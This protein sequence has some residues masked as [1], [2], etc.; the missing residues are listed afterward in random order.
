MMNYVKWLIVISV[1]CQASEALA[2]RSAERLFARCARLMSGLD[3]PPPA[4]M[5]QVRAGDKSYVDACI[6][7]L[8]RGTLNSTTGELADNTGY[9]RNVLRHL[10]NLHFSWL[11]SK[12]IIAG[13]TSHFRFHRDLS[14][15]SGPALFF[16]RAL[17][18]DSIDARF[19]LNGQHQEAIR[20][21]M[22]PTAPMLITGQFSDPNP[23]IITNLT[24]ANRGALIGVRTNTT[25]TFNLTQVGPTSMNWFRTFGRGFIG[26]QTYIASVQAALPNADGG[27]RMPRL[28]GRNV[29]A[30]ALCMELPVVRPEDASGF[31]AP[32]SP[33][34]FRNELGCVGCHAS[35]DRTAAVI[36]NLKMQRLGNNQAPY[37][38]VT[39]VN[40]GP[41]DLAAES[42]WPRQPD[43]QYHR[44][45]TNGRL[46]F[47]NH[48]GALIDEPVSGISNLGAKIL[49]QDDFYICLAKRYYEYFTGVSANVRDLRGQT[50]LEPAASHRQ[51]VIDMGLRLKNHRDLK[52]TIREIFGSPAFIGRQPTP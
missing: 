20:T 33:I 30:D 18:D 4:L 16:T 41:T 47:R 31:V 49:A 19:I 44:R 45:P 25:K 7:V 23:T 43:A 32:N 26:T 35:M 21:N 42:Q 14:D 3:N 17:F 15:A 27:V 2:E 46:F 28:W 10:H 39:R 12:D 38:G 5:N 52:Q 11:T 24:F 22:N 13:S 36:R 34:T 37:L 6:E 40:P 48:A 29:Y 1:F 50:L 9:S 8:N 51:T